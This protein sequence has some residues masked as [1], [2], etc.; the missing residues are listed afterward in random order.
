MTSIR[1][2]AAVNM[3]TMNTSTWVNDSGLSQNALNNSFDFAANTLPE[4]EDFRI[5]GFVLSVLGFPGNVLI[6]AVYVRKLITSTRV[7]MFALG[8]ADFAVCLCGIVMTLFWSQLTMIIFGTIFTFSVT[9]SMFLLVFVSIDRL[10]AVMRPHSFNVKAQRAKKAMIGVV[11]ASVVFTAVMIT[12]LATQYNQVHQ[13]T[14][15]CSILTCMF[16][17]A[18]CYTVLVLLLLKR[19]RGSKHHV[20]ER[21]RPSELSYVT[22]TSTVTTTVENV[23][24]PQETGHSNVSMN[25]ETSSP[26]PKSLS[27]ISGAMPPVSVP[28]TKKKIKNQDNTYRNVVLLFIISVAFVVCWLPDWI[29]ST[30]IYIPIG[31]TR[32]YVLNSVVNPFIYGIASAMFRED[33]R[34]FY[35][36][37]RA[38][39]FACNH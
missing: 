37:T 8:I 39:L 16:I 26:V 36:Q 21:S 24:V 1:T 3:E 17:M 6:I 2:M 4:K 11:V 5:I 33:V 18:T 28:R 30:G 19:R 31:V 20:K 35:R 38:R 10:I 12:S 23:A 13:L 14:K 27:T 32:L 29:S 9:F 34:E 22:V 7:Y 15:L 25:I